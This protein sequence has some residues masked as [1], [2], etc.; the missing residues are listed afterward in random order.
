VGSTLRVRSR[1]FPAVINSTSINWFH[2]WPEEALNNVARRFLAD[3]DLLSGPLQE[4]VAS[5]M[6]YVH[7]SVND[8]SVIYLQN[9]KRYNYTTPKSFLEQI[10][11]YK[12]LLRIKHKELQEKIVRLENGLVK[13]NS[14]SQQ[15][16]DLKEKLAAQ[17]VE[18]AQ[19]NEDADKLIKNVSV[20]SEKVGKEKA[21]ADDEQ[22]K[23]CF[24]FLRTYL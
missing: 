3:V 10:A 15:V 2:E 24:W 14:T 18:V 21:I 12:R 22:A 13:L 23:V 9:D 17:E 5:F 19:K 1:K 4:S 20:E 8:I 6:A 16:D 11:L 7:K